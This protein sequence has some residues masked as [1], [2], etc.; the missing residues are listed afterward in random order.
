MGPYTSPVESKF[1]DPMAF[2]QNFNPHAVK[3]WFDACANLPPDVRSAWT[4][5]VHRYKGYCASAGL[6][7]FVESKADTNIAIKNY[8]WTQRQQFVRFLRTTK[9]LD[10]LKAIR[11]P[12]SEARPE[13]YGFSLD[14][15]VQFRLEDP[16][17]IKTLMRMRGGYRFSPLRDSHRRYSM[18]LN[19]GLIVYVWNGQIISPNRWF[20]GYE[21]R[22]PLTPLYPDDGVPAD[23]PKFIMDEMWTP[24]IKSV[25]VPTSDALWNKLYRI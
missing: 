18:T 17:W 21:I 20:V 4:I 9:V 7:P 19:P 25:R 12:E 11:N 6:S 14:V 1:P 16:T 23:K 13:H 22:C 15:R 2:P 8:L 5:A 3:M 24:L 10:G